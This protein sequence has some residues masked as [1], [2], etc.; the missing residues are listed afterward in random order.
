MKKRSI[1]IKLNKAEAIIFYDYLAK[2]N[3][4][5]MLDDLLDDVGQQVFFNIES[6]LERSLTEVLDENYLAILEESKKSIF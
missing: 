3:D 1:K 5:S 4:E 6:I 2:I